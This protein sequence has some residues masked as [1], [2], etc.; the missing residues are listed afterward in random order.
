MISMNLFM[1]YWDSRCEMADVV[2]SVQID[3]K[4]QKRL[5]EYKLDLEKK[6]GRRIS[7]NEAIR[8]LL[9]SIDRKVIDRR[10]LLRSFGL[11][12]ETKISEIFRELRA[13]EAKR[14]EMWWRKLQEK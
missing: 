7:Y 9:D 5:F 11:A 6:L 1:L 13:E 8:H 12:R 14:D 2:T 4:T 3:E 10:E